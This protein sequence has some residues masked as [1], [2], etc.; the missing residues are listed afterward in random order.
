MPPKFWSPWLQTKT[1]T[2]F[3]QQMDRR[4]PF[5]KEEEEEEMAEEDLVEGSFGQR[6][7]FLSDDL[8]EV[9][10]PINTS[11]VHLSVLILIVSPSFSWMKSISACDHLTPVSK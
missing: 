7:C 1:E 5:E 2:V 11:G 3:F 8:D 9:P 6:S 4:G 10:W